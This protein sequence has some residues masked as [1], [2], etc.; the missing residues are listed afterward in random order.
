MQTAINMTVKLNVEECQRLKDLAV[1]KNRTSH[2]LMKEAI[3]RYIE[4]EEAEQ[5]AIQIAAASIAHYQQTGLHVTLDEVKTWANALK[6]NRE[7]KI[8]ACH[9]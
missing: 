4:D 7:A 6:T 2:F 9:E 8:P 5:T 3:K 1:A